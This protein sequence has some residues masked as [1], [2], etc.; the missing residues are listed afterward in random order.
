MLAKY[1]N[2]EQKAL[3][4]KPLMDGVIRSVF[5]MTEPA[6]ASSDASNIQCDI[7][8]DGNECVVVACFASSHNVHP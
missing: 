3:Y 6:V 4:L 5:L 2:A 8:R 1:G 7:R